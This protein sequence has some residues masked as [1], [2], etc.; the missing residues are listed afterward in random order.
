[1]AREDAALGE[2]PK[3]PVLEVDRNPAAGAATAQA[4]QTVDAARKRGR[5]P[6]GT[7]RPSVH[8]PAA[9]AQAQAEMDKALAALYAPENWVG[10]VRAP[11]DI[12]LAFTGDEIWDLPDREVNVLAAQAATAGRYFLASDPKWVA[13]TLFL[14]SVGTTYGSRAAMSWRKRAADAG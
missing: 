9:V 7:N 10:I 13:L 4:A 6:G 2:L 1:M 14:F 12:A 8:P 5:K 11:A 3:T